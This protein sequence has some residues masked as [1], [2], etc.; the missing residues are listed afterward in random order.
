MI[1]LEALRLTHSDRPTLRGIHILQARHRFCTFITRHMKGL[2]RILSR[3]LDNGCLVE[4]ALVEVFA[5]FG[6]IPSQDP[7]FTWTSSTASARAFIQLHTNVQLLSY[8][9]LED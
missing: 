9:I 3:L 7:R 2:R 1:G 8:T 4:L 5:S 6:L